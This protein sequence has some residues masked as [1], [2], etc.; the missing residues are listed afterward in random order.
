MRAPLGRL[1]TAQSVHPFRGYGSDKFRGI[2]KYD[3]NAYDAYRRVRR[4]ARPL[5]LPGRVF[6]R[7]REEGA[8]LIVVVLMAM[9]MLAALLV[10]SANL[11]LSARRTTG[12][13]KAVLPAQYSAESGMAYAK[14]L[15]DASQRI[16]TNSTLPAG[17]TY[18]TL[19]SWIASLCPSAA[20]IPVP[21]YIKAT[22]GSTI[23]TGTSVTV[24]QSAKVCDV[25]Q[26]SVSQANFFAQLISNSGAAA[27]AYTQAGIPAT[28]VADRQAFFDK[29]F[30]ANRA[31]LVNGAQVQA[32]LRPVTLLQT[33]EYAY[34]LYFR[35]SGVDS[36]GKSSDSSRRIFVRGNETVHA[37]SFKFEVPGIPPDEPK[38]YE[39][40]SVRKPM[41]K[42]R[43]YYGYGNDFSGPFHTNSIPSFRGV[44]GTTGVKNGSSISIDGA[45]TSAGYSTITTNID[46]QGNRVDTPRGT[47]VNGLVNDV[48]V[49]TILISWPAKWVRVELREAMVFTGPPK[50]QAELINRFI[51]R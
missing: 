10:I 2:I 15:L 39:L 42:S 12:E 31:T 4:G 25:P 19:K 48:V 21:G 47:R 9:L 29:V 11:S 38:F 17:T 24:P 34:A 1:G 44:Y 50:P 18:G 14:S 41:G 3:S 28:S 8:G 46:A 13:Q 37:F 16:M 49:V 32:G 27:L 26:F 40:W 20:T 7:H 30:S 5:H 33:D 51:F 22:A 43:G 6:L 23:I 45:L 35:V 36:L